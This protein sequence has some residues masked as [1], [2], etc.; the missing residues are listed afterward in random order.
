[1]VWVCL[2]KVAKKGP[3]EMPCEIADLRGIHEDS[4]EDDRERRNN[5]QSQFLPHRAVLLATVRLVTKVEYTLTG[6]PKA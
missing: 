5:E 6:S 4:Q 2:E 1:M 3:Q